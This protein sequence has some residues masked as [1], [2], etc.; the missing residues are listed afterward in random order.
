MP[1]VMLT[2][3]TTVDFEA[4]GTEEVGLYWTAFH[5]PGEDSE[6][7]EVEEVYLYGE[8]DYT[9]AEAQRRFPSLVVAAIW[10]LTDD[11]A[12]GYLREALDEEVAESWSS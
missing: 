7:E 11:L 2:T 1:H 4:F 5:T 8:G 6:L 3:V 10:D 12:D 9:L